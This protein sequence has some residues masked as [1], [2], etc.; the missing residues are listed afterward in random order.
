MNTPAS[1][2]FPRA[3]ASGILAMSIGGVLAGG[4]L[5][6]G[7]ANSHKGFGFSA[8]N[9][10][11]DSPRG[12]CET[13]PLAGGSRISG[14]NA[15]FCVE[16]GRKTLAVARA[17][18]GLYRFA[19]VPLPGPVFDNRPQSVKVSGGPAWAHRAAWDSDGN[20]L[21]LTDPPTYSIFHFSLAS[22]ILKRVVA[23][24]FR[25]GQTVSPFAIRQRDAGFILED[26]FQGR[27]LWLDHNYAQTHLL[28]LKNLLLA[29]SD[30]VAGVRAWI[31]AKSDILVLADVQQREASSL[32]LLRVQLPEIT[33]DQTKGSPLEVRPVSIESVYQWA[34]GDRL[35]QHARL[36]FPVMASAKGRAFILVSGELSRICEVTHG[37]RCFADVP[38]GYEQFPLI[39]EDLSGKE[40]TT[41]YSV[42]ENVKIATALYGWGDFLYL[43]LR[44]PDP[45][46]TGE[47]V[48]SLAKIDPDTGTVVETMHLPAHSANLL[49]VPGFT[50][51]ALVEQEHVTGSGGRDLSARV[52]AFTMLSGEFFQTIGKAPVE[53]AA[54]VAR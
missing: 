2:R 41:T 44:Q 53:L 54:R 9:M 37:L 30:I 18:F 52:V 21:L 46:E 34:M 31:E 48:W 19:R 26:S 16:S 5:A 12:E 27:L 8:G 15:P 10:A 6:R 24:D 51:W 20:A 4:G 14:L 50:R 39:R 47:T 11:C 28:Q 22:G 35:R 32:K 45:G 33:A 25:S 36:G 3:I 49:L 17:S 23:S 1:Y 43:L 38:R 13:T 7:G 42:L 40:W 29:N